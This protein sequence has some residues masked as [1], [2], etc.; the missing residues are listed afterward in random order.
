[1]EGKVLDSLLGKFD[2]LG[3]HYCPVRVYYE[4]TDAGG[5]VY[6][7][8]YLKFFERGRTNYFTLLL[9]DK[10]KLH[11]KKIN[12]IVRSCDIKYIK[13]AV[14]NDNLFVKTTLIRLRNQLIDFEQVLYRYKDIIVKAKIRIVFVDESG[15]SCNLSKKTIS[16]LKKLIKD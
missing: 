8:N 9:N 13:P 4:D 15:N 12:F 11:N 1:M 6:Y 10:E 14:L 3:S 2:S 16:I 5:I 7:A